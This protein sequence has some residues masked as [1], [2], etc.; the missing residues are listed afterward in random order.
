[1]KK[2]KPI[3]IPSDLNTDDY[4]RGIKKSLMNKCNPNLFIKNEDYNDYLSGKY[5]NETVG[6][7]LVNQ[8]SRVL[9]NLRD[10]VPDILYPGY[11]SIL[12][13][14]TEVG[15]SLEMAAIREIKEEIGYSIPKMRVYAK[16]IDRAGQGDLVTLFIAEIDKRS[17]ELELNEGRKLAYFSCQEILHAHITPYHKEVLL[18][19]FN[20]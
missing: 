18:H 6:V 16:T 12:G 13:G 5:N 9:L 4:N 3:E 17:E 2:F 20:K 11:W 7:I 10:L 19:F 14:H 8:C 1:M 15:E